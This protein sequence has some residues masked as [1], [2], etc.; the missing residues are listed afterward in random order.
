MADAPEI[1]ADEDLRNFV[2]TAGVGLHCVGSDGTILWANTADYAPLG[3]CAQE[4][5]GQPITKFHVDADVINDILVRLHRGERLSNYPAR[6]RCKDGSLRCVE[7]SSSVRFSDQ[8]AFLHTRCF[9]VD[10]TARLE[11]GRLLQEQ[12]EELKKIGEFRDRFLSIAA[13]DLR[14]PLA[15]IVTG[16]QFLLTDDEL[17]PRLSKVVARVVR[18]S[19]RMGRMVTDLFDFTRG[20]LAGGLA[21]MP[22]A[23]DMGELVSRIVE[24]CRVTSGQRRIEFARHGDL[25]G[26]WDADRIAQVVTNLVGNALAHGQGVI[27]R[28]FGWEQSKRDPFRAQWW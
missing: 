2:D 5:I 13:H 8:G 17:P 27:K 28:C 6:L 1:L 18:A 20:R 10:I 4:Y 16:S 24:E 26:S 9:T 12:A 25:Q 3:Y 21:I 23:L 22:T 15:V 14:G 19:E 11:T 7:I